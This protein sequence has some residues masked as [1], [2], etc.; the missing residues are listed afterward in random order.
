MPSYAAL[1]V[2]GGGTGTSAWANAVRDSVVIEC[3]SSTR[4][5]S[6]HEGMLVYET[7]TDRY[8]SYNG[9][10]WVYIAWNSSS[11]RVAFHYGSPWAPGLVSQNVPTATWT[12]VIWYQGYPLSAPY[13][14]PAGFRSGGGASTA[15]PTAPISGLFSFDCNVQFTTA[16]TDTAAS[17]R[18]DISGTLIYRAGDTDRGYIAGSWPQ[19][20]VLTSDTIKVQ[21]Y[22]ASGSTRTMQ[23]SGSYFR[24]RY[25]GV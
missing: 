21:V 4:P 10:S 3:T 7:N 25:V 22:Q 9:T 23:T 2:A 1:T 5:S 8:A 15:Q 24:G 11:G 16:W 18:L 19:V 12:D 14:D 13:Y 17:I 20:E 6:P